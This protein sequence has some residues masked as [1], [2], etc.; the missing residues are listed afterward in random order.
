MKGNPMR[1]EILYNRDHLWWAGTIKSLLALAIIAGAA[2]L[3]TWMILNRL[4][5]RNTATDAPPPSEGP[6]RILEERFARG[7]IDEAEFRTRRDVLRN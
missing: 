4:P 1:H 2:I 7:E 3:I 6:L 5:R